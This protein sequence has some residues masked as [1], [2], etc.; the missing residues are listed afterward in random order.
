[1]YTVTINGQLTIVTLC[2]LCLMFVSHFIYHRLFPVLCTLDRI[3][4]IAPARF[5]VH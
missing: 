4:I 3:L 5:V 1:M 2:I